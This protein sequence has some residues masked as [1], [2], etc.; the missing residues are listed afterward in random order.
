VP[1]PTSPAP[2]V[3]LRSL[4][5]AIPDFPTPGILFRDITPLLLDPVALAHTVDLLSEYAAAR[6]VECVVAA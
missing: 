6:E 5:R 4:I 2:P 1:R 3:D